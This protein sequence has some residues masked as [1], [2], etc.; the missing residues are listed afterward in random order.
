[1]GHHGS[2]LDDDG[3]D[4]DDEDNNEEVDTSVLIPTVDVVSL[5]RQ[6]Q[7]G[8]NRQHVCGVSQ[9]LMAGICV[10]VK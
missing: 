1:M 6:Q 8:G 2:P 3:D 7:D 9:G 5:E 4:D 10:L